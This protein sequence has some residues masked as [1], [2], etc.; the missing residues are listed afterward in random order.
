M[1]LQKH[2]KTIN[3]PPYLGYFQYVFALITKPL[4]KQVGA[5]AMEQRHA[6]VIELRAHISGRQTPGLTWCTPPAFVIYTS[7]GQPR[8]EPGV[9]RPEI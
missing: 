5:K 9:W 7:G 2:L 8:D 3:L 6:N 4:L 1:L